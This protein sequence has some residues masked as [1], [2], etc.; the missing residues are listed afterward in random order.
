MRARFHPIPRGWPGD[1]LWKHSEG[2]IGGFMDDEDM[3]CPECGEIY[4]TCD[5]DD[6][7]DNDE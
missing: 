5:V 1:M 7:G 4:C 3:H 2:E 6:E